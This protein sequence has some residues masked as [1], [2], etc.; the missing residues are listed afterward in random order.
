MTDAVATWQPHPLNRPLYPG[1]TL[2]TWCSAHM[3][4]TDH[5]WD[6]RKL[7]CLEC[8]PESKPKADGD[9]D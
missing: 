5:L 9:H 1:D 6:G 2:S 3:D 7:I 4:R 8:H